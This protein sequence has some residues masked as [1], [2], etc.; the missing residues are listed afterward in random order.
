MLDLCTDADDAALVEIAQRRLGNV[1][2]VARDFLRTQLRVPRFNL[3]LFNVQRRVIV[4]PHQLFADENGILEVVATPG[5][6]GHQDVASQTQLALLR[7]R[8]VGDHLPLVH[9][10]AL[11]DNRFLVD[12][13]ILV[14]ALELG[15]LID[16]GA[17]FAR[18]LRRVVFALDT[19]D[20][21]LGID[22]VNDAVTTCQHH[23]TGIARGNAFHSR[24]DKRSFGNQQRHR[25]A[26]HVGPHQGAIGVVVLKERNQRGCH[27][28]QLFRTDVYIGNFAAIDQDEVALTPRRDQLALDAALFVEFDV[29]L[30]DGVPI[31]LPRRQIEAE[32]LIFHGS[33]LLFDQLMVALDGVRL[34]KMVAHAQS[35]VAGVDDLHKV[36]Q[37]AIANAAVRRLDKAI[38]VDAR[39]A[40]E[41]RNQA[42]VRAFRRLNRADAAIVRRMHVAHFEPGTLA[43]QTTRPKRRQTPLVGDLRQRIGLIHEL[44]QLRAAEEFTD[45]RHHRLG[46]DQIVRH[47]RR[48]VRID[49]HLFLDGALHAD[50]PDAELVLHQLADR[51]HTA[52]AEMIDVIH[53]A[54]VLA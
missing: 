49:A 25:L 34:F 53:I 16:V 39:K 8:S 40:G 32:R 48:H 38:L 14:G 37:E 47:R 1:G 54:N 22:R 41:R 4:L 35:A 3:V 28:N 52:V 5:H 6:E 13:G 46:V 10:L 21:A 33:L 11:T 19:H 17:H 43:T 18:Q 23:R 51:A 24:A 9:A 45:R 42:D 31:F 12:A 30:R 26:L 36:Q 15:E 29:G 20:D 2:N 50:Q 27:R 44:R 7:A